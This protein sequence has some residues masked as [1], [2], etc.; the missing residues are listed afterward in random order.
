[1]V[2]R[3]VSPSEATEPPAHTRLCVG[4]G[5][6]RGGGWAGEGVG[7]RGLGGRGLGGRGQG[8]FPFSCHILHYHMVLRPKG[9][10]H[11]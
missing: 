11:K 2:K 6:G 1:M 5:G 7:R 8:T 4:G 10:S 9:T 3:T